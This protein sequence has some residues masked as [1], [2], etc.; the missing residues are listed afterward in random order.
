MPKQARRWRCGS[1]SGSSNHSIN[2]CLSR[3][4]SQRRND[5]R[6]PVPPQSS[7][8]CGRGGQWAS[9]PNTLSLPRRSCLRMPSSFFLG[10]DQRCPAPLCE[11]RGD[12]LLR[13]PS[14]TCSVLLRRFVPEVDAPPFMGGGVVDAVRLKAVECSKSFCVRLVGADI[15]AVATDDPTHADTLASA[16]KQ[17]SASWKQ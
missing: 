8:A 10:R 11:V 13:R 1:V 2:R 9:L 3:P 14:A 7:C 12:R 6:P 16:E 15:L 5:Q 4:C 17:I